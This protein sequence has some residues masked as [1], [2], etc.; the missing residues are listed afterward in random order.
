[1]AG[2]VEQLDA[3]L[4]EPGDDPPK[5]ELLQLSARALRETPDSIAREA[6]QWVGSLPLGVLWLKPG[7]TDDLIEQPTTACRQLL[8]AGLL[9]SLGDSKHARA[10]I[11]QV[12]AL[13]AISSGGA[14]K[15]GKGPV[16][17]R[18]RN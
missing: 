2:S 18:R 14:G 11:D 15:L 16:T 1:V 10:V 13:R 12:A 3:A 4:N 17:K 6:C 7:A 9:R 8:A 5:W